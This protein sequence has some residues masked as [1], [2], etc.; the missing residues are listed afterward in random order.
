VPH[1]ALSVHF[2]SGLELPLFVGTVR[3]IEPALVLEP[4][5]RSVIELVTESVTGPVIEI[6]IVI[7]L[8]T[9]PVTLLLNESVIKL[10]PVIVI[11][12]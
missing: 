4:V 12:A 5:T 11:Q 7:E 3:L 2:Q 9:E 1:P 10:E 6:L 8:V